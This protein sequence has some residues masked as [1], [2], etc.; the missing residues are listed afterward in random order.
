MT[1]MDREWVEAMAGHSV[2][3]EEATKFLSDFNDW[4]DNYVFESQNQEYIV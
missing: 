4:L 3:D 1:D 2:S